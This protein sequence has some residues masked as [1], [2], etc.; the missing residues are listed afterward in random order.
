MDFFGS[1]ILQLFKKNAFQIST[2]YGKDILKMN[3]FILWKQC[4]Q[5]CT[6]PLSD[7]ILPRTITTDKE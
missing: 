4:T 5:M 6:S 3:E 1:N 2:I 7:Q